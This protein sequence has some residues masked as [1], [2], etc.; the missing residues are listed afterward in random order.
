VLLIHSQAFDKKLQQKTILVLY[1]NID[2]KKSWTDECDKMDYHPNI[3]YSTFA[4]IEKVK[5]KKFDYVVV[6][7]AHL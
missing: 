6:D 4:S 5:D 7:E 1:P 2:I 3:T